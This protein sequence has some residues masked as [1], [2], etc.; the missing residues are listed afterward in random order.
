MFTNSNSIGNP[1]STPV[2]AATSPAASPITVPSEAAALLQSLLHDNNI[3]PSS[4]NP[5][6]FSRDF[7]LFEADEAQFDYPLFESIKMHPQHPLHP[8]QQLHAIQQHAQLQQQQQ[9]QQQHVQLQNVQQQHV[10]Q[11][12][13]AQHVLNSNSNPL[14]TPQTPS[15]DLLENARVTDSYGFDSFSAFLEESASSHSSASEAAVALIHVS[16]MASHLANVNGNGADLS[17]LHF[18]S[19]SSS[20]AN[21]VLVD[22]PF[23]P[24]LDTP[25]ETPYLSDFGEE[26]ESVNSAQVL[27]GH[28]NNGCGGSG[29][30]G[31][32]GSSSG[33]SSVPLFHEFD[34]EIPA[35]AHERCAYGNT[36]EPATL[37]MASPA[38]Y[39]DLD[40]SQESDS[41][42]CSISDI[43]SAPASPF[44]LKAACKDSFDEGQTG[45]GGE[46]LDTSGSDISLSYE[47]N[48][49]DE[50]DENEDVDQDDDDDEFIPSRPLAAAASGSTSGN[51]RKAPAA[52]N[53]GRNPGSDKYTASASP[54]KRTRPELASPYGGK[55]K[56]SLKAKQSASNRRFPCKHPGCGL[57]FAR[58]YNLHTH[59]RTHDPH[60]IRPFICSTDH[61][62]KG[63]S[64]KHDLQRHEASVHMG[65]R[66]YRCQTCEKSFSRQDGLRRHLTVKSSSCAIANPNIHARAGDRNEPRWSAT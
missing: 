50:E 14:C 35:N 31:V 37:F 41:S 22:T 5:N 63:F 65:E 2:S 23:T 45:Q 15:L 38:V 43:S 29:I 47:D 40:D 61:C 62:R 10:Q 36:I 46:D 33:Y 13:Q 7:C 57:R 60:Q 20:H 59:E 28:D 9:Q 54:F 39:H 1:A 51:K 11:H 49:E 4:T 58:L 66:N 21:H 52:T 16:D 32:R 19:S 25:F 48:E 64:R 53:Y 26:S 12:Q 27:F 42:S 18:S 56:M 3:M 8:L 30:N 34:F 44:V 6:T 55:K 17:T 24:Y